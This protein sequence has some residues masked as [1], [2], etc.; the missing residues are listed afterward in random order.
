MPPNQRHL[1]TPAAQRGLPHPLEPVNQNRCCP[2]ELAPQHQPRKAARQNR[3]DNSD[4]EKRTLPNACYLPY[5]SAAGSLTRNFLEQLSSFESLALSKTDFCNPTTFYQ[6]AVYTTGLKFPPA[7]LPTNQ[8]AKQVLHLLTSKSNCCNE[9]P[10]L[11]QRVA[12]GETPV[13][14]ECLQS[15]RRTTAIRIRS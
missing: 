6:A 2:T 1:D 14:K 5:V 4:Q 9:C 15:R 11:L 13:D 12:E 8:T 7:S 3:P 10:C